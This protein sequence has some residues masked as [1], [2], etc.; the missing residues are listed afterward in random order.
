[1]YSNRILEKKKYLVSSGI[2]LTGGGS[3]L[4]GNQELAEEVFKL[5]VRIGV[6]HSVK[7]FRDIISSPLYAT[8][9]GLLEIGWERREGKRPSRSFFP[10]KLNKSFRKVKGFF[11]DYF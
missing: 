8:A 2:V 10:K 7:G 6:P 9:V 11:S 4:C 1:M 5:P 3:L